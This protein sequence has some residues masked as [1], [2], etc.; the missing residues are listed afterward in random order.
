MRQGTGAT[1]DDEGTDWKEGGECLDAARH[2]E[3]EHRE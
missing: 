3:E 2:H 1:E